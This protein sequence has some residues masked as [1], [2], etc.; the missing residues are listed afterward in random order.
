MKLTHVKEHV[1]GDCEY[2]EVACVYESLGVGVKI[3]RKDKENHEKRYRE[4][5][6]DLSMI[7]VRVLSE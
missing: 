2:T 3:L 1:S 5:H 6:L 4:N 7:T